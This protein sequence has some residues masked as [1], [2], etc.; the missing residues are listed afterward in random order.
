VTLMSRSVASMAMW[1]I[2]L[3]GFVATRMHTS[4][5]VSY[6]AAPANH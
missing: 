3:A 5:T 6:R 1:I 4:S 2:H